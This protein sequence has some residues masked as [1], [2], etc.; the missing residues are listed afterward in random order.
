MVALNLP[1]VIYLKCSMPKKML[2][3]AQMLHSLEFPD[4]DVNAKVN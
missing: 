1:F 4:L 3:F 2:V